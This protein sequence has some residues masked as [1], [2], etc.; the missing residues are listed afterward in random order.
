MASISMKC[1]TVMSEFDDGRDTKYG[2]SY[3][4]PSQAGSSLVVAGV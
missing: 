2:Y 1:V 4:L 3:A